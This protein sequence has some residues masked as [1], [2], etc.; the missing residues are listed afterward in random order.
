ML[1]GRLLHGAQQTG[2]KAPQLRRARKGFNGWEL[3]LAK[4]VCMPT[5]IYIHIYIDLHESASELTSMEA[6]ILS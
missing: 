5:V 3:N 2:K 1:V 6:Q 4:S